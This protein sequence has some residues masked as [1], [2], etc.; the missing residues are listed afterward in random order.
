VRN[1]KRFLLR[2]AALFAGENQLNHQ[3][4]Q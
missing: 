2:T 3:L 4:A 1:K